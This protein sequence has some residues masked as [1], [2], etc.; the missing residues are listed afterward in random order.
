MRAAVYRKYGPPSVVT[1]ADVPKPQPKDNEVLIRIMATTVTSG[2]WRARSLTLPPGFDI[3]GRLVFGLTGPRQPILGTEL[4]GVIESVGSAVT[5]FQPGDEVIAFPG[6]RYGSHAEYRTMPEDGM[7]AMKPANL[8][9]EEA[10]SLSF[11]STTALPFLRDS[12]KI[13]KGDQVL[14]VGASG[15]VGTAAVQIARHFGAEVTAVTSTGNLNLVRAIGADR[16]IDYTKVDF[17]TTGETW[18]IILDTTGTAPFSR[19]EPALKPGGRLVVVSGTFAQALGIGAPS[20]ASGKH[21]IARVVPLS[22]GDLR[23]I[24]DLAADGELK[25]VIDRVYPLESAAEAHTYVDTGRKRG[26][27]VLTVVPTSSEDENC[28]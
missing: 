12:A 28:S 11:G 20:K 3:L 7:I 8:S 25:P 16:A 17:A 13:K 26:S 18:D 14:V 6:G 24:A 15:A 5:R 10:A 21:V 27:V 23:Y 19:C 4:A 2:D 9:F 1:L 22:A